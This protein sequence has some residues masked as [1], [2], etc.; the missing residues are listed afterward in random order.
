VEA[1]AREEVKGQT[2]E[3]DGSRKIDDGSKKLWILVY[4]EV[5]PPAET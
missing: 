3:D 2:K 4:V 5:V 1:E